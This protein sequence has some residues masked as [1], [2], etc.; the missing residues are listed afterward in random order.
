MVLPPNMSLIR[1]NL[2]LFSIYII[3]DG[4]FYNKSGLLSILIG[5]AILA[6]AF[7]WLITQ[8]VY[9]YSLD[10][11]VSIIT[12]LMGLLLGIMVYSGHVSEKWIRG[13]LD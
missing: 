9:L 3:L 1:L 2:F 12:G 13:A 8:N 11:V 7:I 10:V 5:L 4:I 6:S